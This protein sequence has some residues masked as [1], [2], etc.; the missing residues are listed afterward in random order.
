MTGLLR[1]LMPSSVDDSELSTNDT[2]CC[3]WIPLEPMA[4]TPNDVAL[5]GLDFVYVPQAYVFL[6]AAH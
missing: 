1:V 6:G 4:S 5:L 2:T 3:F